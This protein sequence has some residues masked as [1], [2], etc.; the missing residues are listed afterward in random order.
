MS[1]YQIDIHKLA[2]DKNL[3]QK[4]LIDQICKKFVR[5]LSENE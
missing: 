4:I 1:Q 5:K 3:W 2:R